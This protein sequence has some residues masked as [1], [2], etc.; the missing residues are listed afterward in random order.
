VV[1]PVS[2]FFGLSSFRFC[3]Y[4]NDTSIYVWLVALALSLIKKKKN[5]KL[6]IREASVLQ[7]ICD[8]FQESFVSHKICDHFQELGSQL[9][10]LFF[11]LSPLF[12][13]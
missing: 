5:S 12:S 2:L 6:V 13:G 7:N 10:P 4:N 9:S 3:S 11:Q 1:L 8:K